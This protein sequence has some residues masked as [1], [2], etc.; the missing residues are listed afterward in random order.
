MQVDEQEDTSFWDL[1]IPN[2]FF[3]IDTQVQDSIVIIISPY[4]QIA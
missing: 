1:P 3:G 4:I 2:N